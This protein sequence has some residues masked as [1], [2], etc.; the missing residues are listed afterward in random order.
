MQLPIIGNLENPVS[1]MARKIRKYEDAYGIEIIDNGRAM[2]FDKFKVEGNWIYDKLKNK[3]YAYIDK[4]I[5]FNVST[6]LQVGRYRLHL[7]DAPSAATIKLARETAHTGPVEGKPAEIEP[8]STVFKMR[9]TTNII[10]TIVDSNMLAN[11]FRI[12]TDMGTLLLVA[13]V[14]FL[15]GAVTGLPFGGVL[16]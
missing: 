7:L 3:K 15:I 5:D 2:N 16:Q 14:M 4:T 10:S 12:K 8:D 6:P 13:A 9:G 11:N 1:S